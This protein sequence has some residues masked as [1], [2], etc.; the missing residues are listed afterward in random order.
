MKNNKQ[1]LAKLMELDNEK[2][3][4]YLADFANNLK[5]QIQKTDDNDTIIDNLELLK[6]FIYKVPEQA[7]EIIHYVIDNP[8]PPKT[9]K[10]VFGK[11]E[12]KKY[13]EL[14]TKAIELL[15]LIRYIYPDKALPI[16]AKLILSKSPEIST[17]AKETLKHFA[18]YDFNVLTKSKIGYGAQRKVLDY[19]LAWSIEE[20]AKNFDF[21]EVAANELLG[22]S[23][24]GSTSSLNTDDQYTLTMHFGAVQPTDFLKKMRRQ[25]ID[26]VFNLYQNIADESKKVRLAKVL[27]EAVRTPGNVAY[28]DDLAQLF[29][30]DAKYL[31]AIYRKMLF[32]KDGKLIGSIPVAEEIEKRLYWFHRN[33][34]FD[35]E[36]TQELRASILSDEFYSLFRLFA[37]D[38]VTFREENGWDQAVPKRE[39]AIDSIVD[40]IKEEEV[41]KWIAIL[42]RVA[43][44]VG[45]VAEWQFNY[46]R[47][48]LRKLAEKKSEI[49]SRILLQSIKISAPLQKFTSSILEGLLSAK[50]DDIW[51]RIVDQ[52]ISK[53]DSS[54]IPEVLYSLIVDVR[55]TPKLEIR[56]KDFD[57]LEEIAF[58]SKR[59]KFLSEVENDRILQHALL[60]AIASNFKKDQPRMEKLLFHILR[61]R[62]DQRNAQ[63]RELDFAL[64]KGWIDYSSLSSENV[65][66]LKTWLA[67]IEDLDWDAQSVLHDLGSKDP[68]I[69]L[70]TFW[71]RIERDAKRKATQKLGDF[72][73]Y[74]A[75]PYHFNPELIKQLSEYLELPKYID[76]WLGKMTKEWSPYN[77][78]ISDFLQKLG[79][80]VDETIRSLIKSGDEMSLA[81]AAHLMDRFS[82]YADL[83]LCMS[84]IGKTDDKKI[85]AIVDSILY[86]TGVV[87]GEDGIVRAWEAKAEAMRKFISS[88]NPRVKKYADRLV[89]SFEASAKQEKQRVE[90]GRRLRKM[91]FE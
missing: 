16:I 60:N 46:F 40:E 75:I 74:R 39:A 42:N 53:K 25:T 12:G 78:N 91:E 41:E 20:Q 19:V 58:Q 15:D 76:I 10:E 13:E 57:L 72:S 80:P 1:I 37:G 56:G 34:K 2:A 68:S 79:R 73:H 32:D 36:E 65:D 8:H 88:D 63:L 87:S 7:I 71:L 6:E 86:A 31:L 9:R 49:S 23:V 30:E 27:E 48:F 44:Q 5:V 52:I 29:A 3:D 43:A 81:K 4:A 50:R 67:E 66:F 21:I 54:L 62:I 26:L 47:G 69:I 45:L 11:I 51:D 89:A 82:G 64:I 18:K 35:P 14:V 24:E 70:N 55:F 28:G 85:M 61:R 17:K 38:D 83:D 90:E 59:F 84:I 33:S 77:W 22:S